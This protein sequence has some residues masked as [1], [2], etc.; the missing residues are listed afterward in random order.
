M[1]LRLACL[2]MPNA[3]AALRPLPSSGR[4]KDVEVLA[5]RHQ[6]AVLERQLQGCPC[7]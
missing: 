4:D 6:L 1:L 5:L 3:F 2:T 7:R